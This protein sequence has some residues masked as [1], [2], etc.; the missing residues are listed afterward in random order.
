MFWG[1]AYKLKSFE[2]VG[3]RYHFS[4]TG[5]Q[6]E[7]YSLQYHAI[8]DFGPATDGCHGCSVVHSASDIPENQVVQAV[9][10]VGR[11]RIEEVAFC[12]FGFGSRGST[13]YIIV[14][15][16]SSWGRRRSLSLTL[17]RLAFAIRPCKWTER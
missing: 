9:R 4:K 17:A 7:K 13:V 3:I 8:S 11:D 16:S 1:I 6:H 2:R 12:T 14:Q 10:M 15:H 5:R